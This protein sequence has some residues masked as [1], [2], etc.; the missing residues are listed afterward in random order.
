MVGTGLLSL[1]G[2]AALPLVKVENNSGELEVPLTAFAEGSH[3]IVRAPKLPYDL[4]V[5][6]LPDGSARSVYLRCTHEDQPLTATATG[7]HCPSHGSRFSMDG[8]VEEGPATLPLRTFPVRSEG[9]K[10]IIALGR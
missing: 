7:L 8:S 6:K 3:V 4:L 10:L 1:T 2:C 5:S 9:D